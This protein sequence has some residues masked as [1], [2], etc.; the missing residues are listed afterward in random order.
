[1]ATILQPC[2]AW[3]FRSSAPNGLERT[4]RTRS[5]LAT[6]PPLPSRKAQLICTQNSAFSLPE[7]SDREFPILQRLRDGAGSNT[8]QADVRMVGFVCEIGQPM[9]LPDRGKVSAAL[10]WNKIA[11]KLGSALRRWCED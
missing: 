9:R 6:T 4:C 3:A 8:G 1:M 11:G 2:S 5:T 7:R 10:N